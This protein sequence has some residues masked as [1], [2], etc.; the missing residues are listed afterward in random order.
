MLSYLHHL[1][2]GLRLR[3][4]AMLRRFV[5]RRPNWMVTFAIEEANLSEGMRAACASTVMLLLGML[6]GKPEFAW[7]AIGA[8]WTCLADASGTSRMRLASMLS[9]SFLSTLC[10]GVT[11]YAAGSGIFASA[12]AILV[13][14]TM[15][16]LAR[17][18]GVA[19]YQVAI[20]AATACVVMVD[21][22]LHGVQHGAAFLGIYLGGCLFAT[23]LSITVWRI[24][25]FSPS[26]YALRMAYSRLSELARDN[27]RLIGSDATGAQEWAMHAKELRGQTRAAIEA[28]HRAL[29]NLSQLSLDSGT[30]VHEELLLALADAERSFASLIAVAHVEE[31]DASAFHPKR[32][33]RCLAAIAAILHQRG[34]QLGESR[35][36]Y[37]SALRER[38]PALSQ[39]L[40]AAFGQAMSLPFTS[41]ES[42]RTSPRAEVNRFNA[43]PK[44][45]RRSL[46]IFKD[47][48]SIRLVNVQYAVRLGLTTTIVFLI[49]RALHLPSGCWATMAALLILQPSVA[50]TWPRSVE[51]AVGSALGA[52]LAVGIACFV[53]TPLAISLTVFPLIGLTMGLRPVSYSLYVVFLTPSFV[54]VA[55]Y[56]SSA[57]EFAYAMARL[58]NNVLGCAVAL[59]A[60]YFLWPS[61]ETK[62]LHVALTEAV[63]AHLAYLTAALLRQGSGDDTGCESARRDA[64]LASNRA[65]HTYR[66]VRMESR[67]HDKAFNRIAEVLQL[68]RR[69]AGT[70]AKLQARAGLSQATNELATW[71]EATRDDL[72]SHL[73]GDDLMFQA[74]AHPLDGLSLVETAAVRQLLQLSDLLRDAD[75]TGTASNANQSLPSG[76]N[77]LT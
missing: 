72:L 1:R 16:G 31:V 19:A 77:Y 50:T 65:E 70:A 38:L 45:A 24:R 29:G 25:R 63:Q 66:L 60:T 37:P 26:R 67:H 47:L 57:N 44:V 21:R 43:A 40:E 62:N 75:N 18:W 39:C 10:G 34:E 68:L 42:V 9:F 51:R 55:D 35:A 74:Q 33:S 4:I 69:I 32:A 53:H 5:R 27:A 7:A 15:A 73:R 48:A 12:T 6:V 76:S 22:P 13:F 46:Q 23:L 71:I 36:D 49:V 28:A 8:F 61:R 59:L 14:A 17:I 3:L 11:A 52:M 54:L 64:G 20:V 41:V 2:L 30:Q 58:G 56:A